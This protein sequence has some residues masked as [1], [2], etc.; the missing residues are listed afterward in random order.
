M[1][2]I[3]TSGTSLEVFAPLAKKKNEKNFLYREKKKKR[4]L[5][6]RS[7]PKFFLGIIEENCFKEIFYEKYMKKESVIDVKYI[8][9]QWKL[10]RSAP[11]WSTING[12]RVMLQANQ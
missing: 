7:A 5:M 4:E 1:R 11:K 3:N 6:L 12:W 2:V 8:N 10:E 9:Q